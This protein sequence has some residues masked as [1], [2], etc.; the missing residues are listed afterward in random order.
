MSALPTLPRYEPL[1]GADAANSA[2]VNGVCQ[3]WTGCTRV[4]SAAGEARKINIV[5]SGSW[6]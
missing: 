5:P 4:G 6:L 1:V 3:I 2:V